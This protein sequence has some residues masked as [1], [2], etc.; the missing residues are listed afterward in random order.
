[1]ATRSSTVEFV[2]EQLAD[3]GDVRSRKMF[4]EYAI[5]YQ[6]KRVGLV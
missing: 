1:M 5:Y 2:L 6:E 3:L 4:G